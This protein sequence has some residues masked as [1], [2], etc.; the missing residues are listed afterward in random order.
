MT[1]DA[2]AVIIGGGV[3]GTS[4]AYHLTEL[5]WGDVVLLDR[6]E[7]T[8]GS[9]FHSAGLVGQLRSSV[10]LTR[11]MMYSVE[12]YR[13]LRDDTGIDPGWH[14]VGS[15]RLASSE[16]R[17]QELRRLSGW[18]KT[19]GLPLEI[20]S[21]DRALE[22]FPLFDPSGIR[23]A[24]FLPTDG[25]LDPS[26]LTFALA[27]GARRRGASI[28][29]GVRVTGID[30]ERGRVRGVRT[31][32]GDIRT[33]VVVN[34]GGMYANQLGAMAGVEVPV[35][36]FAHE[37]LL[38]KPIDGVTPNL[39]TMRDPDRLV[40][41]RGEAGGGLV[42]GGYERHP[43][44]W[45]VKDGPPATFNHELLP[46]DWPRFEPLAE[47]AFGLVPAL[48]EAEVVRLINGPEAFTP[49]GEFILGESEVRGFFVAAGFCAHGIAGA[50]GIGKVIAEW[51]V[52]GEPEFDVWKM[53]IRRFGPQYRDRSYAEIRAHE[54]YAT[55]YDIHYPNEERSAGRP[56][57]TAPTYERLRS[58]GAEFGEKSGW[59][60]ANWMR[61]NEDPSLQELR[62]R[63]W[64]G[65]HWSS[66]IPAEHRA[67]RD[68]AG[69]FDESSF[70][71]IEV[72][73][74]GACDFLQYLCANDVDRPVGTV[75]YTQ[76]LNRRGGIESDLTV[77][78]LDEDRFRLVTGTA[79]GNHDLG[80]IRKH[81]PETDPPEV[82]DATVEL[83]CF[84]L[85][86]P[87][88]REIL[89]SVTEADLSNAS[90]PYM[91]ARQVTVTG[92]RCLVQRVSYVGEL[93]WEIY[94]AAEDALGVFEA[95]RSAGSPLGLMLGGYRAID[96]LRLE[97][98]YR[99]WGSDVTP[100]ET[101]LEAGLGFAVG[102]DK[103]ADFIGRAALERQRDGGVTRRLRLL[104]LEDVR[105]VAL[106]NEPVR[107]D[108]RIVAR[109]TSGGLGYSVGES[110]AFAYVPVE[111][112]AAGSRLEVEV[113]GDWIP[114]TVSERPRWD[115]AGAR[116]RA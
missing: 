92:A 87:R 3:G 36:P 65:I 12:L 59:E 39:P 16:E 77:T 42:M 23:G 5:G 64:A 85:W 99:A 89:A 104:V 79:F 109:V 97:K 50:G 93:G 28:R 100:E 27:E 88:A 102:F 95:L 7:L 47:N 13:R 82:R 49:D 84:A 21:T 14:E 53:D 108:G 2:R 62:P 9:T 19:F 26:G 115:P 17:I 6:A 96:S 107:A 103:D 114:A 69:L 80:W 25:H 90:F 1:E 74:P 111:V 105:A 66:A 67:T 32:A 44:P 60:R 22:L 11:M 48:Q 94:P 18:G 81:L 86:G 112:E 76:L 52:H 20:V 4:I 30:V 54:I 68:R 34:A 15:L 71:K 83:C 37:Y 56:L 61:S 75:V 51:I 73:G 101:P 40:Y 110:L 46:E 55:Y 31:D 70:A 41:F 57:K 33:D 38:T 91:R 78:R 113:F 45:M 8:S 72:S 63:G 43:A 10:T 98:A 58:L 106:G 35:V 29:T 116:I 24:A